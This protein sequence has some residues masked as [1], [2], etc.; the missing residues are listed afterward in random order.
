M[1]VCVC[2]CVCVFCVCISLIFKVKSG[3]TCKNSYSSFLPSSN[4]SNF[5][6]VCRKEKKDGA[7]TFSQPDTL[8]NNL[9]YTDYPSVVNG[10]ES[11]VNRALGGSTY[12]G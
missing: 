1:Y 3:P 11:T 6:V 2:V 10:K 8:S 7:A 5:L 12:P 4:A 9:I